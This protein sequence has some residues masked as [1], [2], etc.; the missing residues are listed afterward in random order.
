MIQFIS[1]G[2]Q[3]EGKYSVSLSAEKPADLDIQLL[4]KIFFFFFFFK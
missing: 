2:S 4:S 3:S 1:M